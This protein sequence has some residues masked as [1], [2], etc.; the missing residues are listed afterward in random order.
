MPGGI[1]QIRL[2]EEKRVQI[3]ISLSIKARVPLTPVNPQKL[4][5]IIVTFPPLVE[6]VKGE[7]DVI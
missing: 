7:T 6:A 5:P 2:E 3:S 1:S 4:L